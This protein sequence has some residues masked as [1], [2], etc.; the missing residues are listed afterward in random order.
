MSL[1]LNMRYNLIFP[2]FAKRWVLI[3]IIFLKSEFENIIRRFEYQLI[4][5]FFLIYKGF[6]SAIKR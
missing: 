4:S 2:G 5:R 3:S 1:P 6:Y